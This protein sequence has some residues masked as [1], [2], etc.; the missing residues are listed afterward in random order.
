M[1]GNASGGDFVQQALRQSF[2][3]DLKEYG[4]AALAAPLK[5]LESLWVYLTPVTSHEVSGYKVSSLLP[6]PDAPQHAKSWGE[7]DLTSIQEGTPPKFKP[8]K[9][10]IPGP[11]FGGAA[12]EKQNGNRLVVFGTGMFITNQFLLI[13]DLEVA[14]NEGRFVARFPATANWRPTAP[15]GVRKWIR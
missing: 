7:K 8:D 15:S 3:W 12:V 10:D 1:Q 11:L 14:R 6:L 13:P 4:N 2:I 9:G 5:N